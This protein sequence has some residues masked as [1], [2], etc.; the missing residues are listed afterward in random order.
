[1][2]KTFTDKATTLVTLVDETE[3]SCSS[4]RQSTTWELDKTSLQ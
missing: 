3:A 1:M 2:K 4:R